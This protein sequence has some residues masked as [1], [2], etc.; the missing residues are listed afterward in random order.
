MSN[1]VNMIYVFWSCGDK[2]EAKQVIYELLDQRLIAC[3]SIFPKVESM[4]RWKGKIEESEELKVIL[5]TRASHFNA[6]QTYIQSSCSYE[7]PEIV[8]VDILEASSSYLAW[9]LQETTSN[10]LP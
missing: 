10:E 6:I 7:I 1:K 5:K 8:Q 2:T 3:G 9:L 4:Y